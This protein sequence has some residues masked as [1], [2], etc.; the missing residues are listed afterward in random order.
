MNNISFLK[1]RAYSLLISCMLVSSAFAVGSCDVYASVFS[2]RTADISVPA[3]SELA[4]ALHNPWC[5]WYR[6]YA[7]TLSD[8]KSFDYSDISQN[9]AED[10]D[11]LNI[12]LALVELCLKNYA[13]GAI[14][15]TGISQADSIL[16]AI[17]SAGMGVILRFVYDMD[18]NGEATEPDDIGIVKQHMSQLADVINSHKS[19][20]YTLQG[21][22]VGSWGEMHTSKYLSDADMTDLFNTLALSTAPDI[23]LSVRTPAHYRIITGL[24]SP[25]ERDDAYA[26]D[27]ASRTGLFNDG[28]LG[29]YSDLGTYA[30]EGEENDE[31]LSR[32]DEIAF[33]N[34]LCLYVPN[35]GEVMNDTS[36]SDIENA[37]A[38]L[39]AMHVSYLD[40]DYDESTLR[41]WKN[42]DY[43][44]ELFTDTTGYDYITAHMGYRYL[45][46][47]TD[48]IEA[49][50]ANP[51]LAVKV[52]VE[53]TGFAP[54]YK[55]LNVTA[56]AVKAPAAG[57][58]S[59]DTTADAVSIP[60]AADTRLWLPDEETSFSFGLDISEYKPGDTVNLYIT[61]NDAASGDSIMP[62]NSVGNH[63]YISNDNA[64][65]IGSI[66]IKDKY[67][68][69]P[70]VLT[71]FILDI[72]PLSR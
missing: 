54:C 31:K 49:G 13:D 62:A 2:L 44:D 69:I 50:Y 64:V 57:K 55:P 4:E 59:T 36:F 3:F 16:S 58:S 71:P 56:L 40:A 5:G 28:M 41:K 43:T 9:A 29:S 34:A 42:S 14:S 11:E 12:R 66:S 48:A 26:S 19:G 6:I 52:T 65:F 38:D 24:S 25:I 46:N 39:K 35:G 10:A 33:Q 53:N 17:E 8:D 20:I 1:R 68:D 45:I 72:S 63:D 27:I 32:A 51:M 47:G 37:V 23:F 30:E 15:D 18:G 22:F 60:V 21:V 61:L 67:S 7:Y 70:E